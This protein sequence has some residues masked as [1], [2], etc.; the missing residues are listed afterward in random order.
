MR[1]LLLLILFITIS[2]SLSAYATYISLRHCYERCHF[3][4]ILRWCWEVHYLRFHYYIIIT[5][6][7]AAGCP[8]T[9]AIRHYIGVDITP[10]RFDTLFRHAAAA[11]MSMPPL[12]WISFS[13][14]PCLA[15]YAPPLLLL[16]WLLRYYITITIIIHMPLLAY[17]IIVYILLL[18][19]LLLL[20]LSILSAM[21]YYDILLLYYYYYICHTTSFRSA[22]YYAY[23][24][25]RYFVRPHITPLRFSP[26]AIFLSD[27]AAAI[28]YYY[29]IYDMLCYLMT[30]LYIMILLC[31]WDMIC[32]RNLI[33][34]MKA[35][36]ADADICRRD[37]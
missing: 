12:S 6:G 1:Y 28:L 29:I 18:L 23:I 35:M 37:P 32:A 17:Y 14:Y 25:I 24:I 30:L 2:L 20:M 11:A 13:P 10:L 21:L 31:L 4:T 7:Y 26:Y 9:Y 27:Y 3:L 19:L 5:P 8:S 16:C 22:Y 36:S 33:Y 15:T 34:D